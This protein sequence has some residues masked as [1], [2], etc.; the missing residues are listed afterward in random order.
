MRNRT[1]G[2]MLRRSVVVALACVTG[3]A[4]GSCSPFSN[5][6][7]DSWPHFAG[8]EPSDLPPRPGTPGYE[9]FIAHGH[10]VQ[11]TA[12]PATGAQPP[13]ASATAAVPNTAAIAKPTPA[14]ANQMPPAFA[15][16]PVTDAKPDE[17]EVAP[18]V[19]QPAD[20]KS[21]VQGG[22]Y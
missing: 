8:G 1:V 22:L 21:V 4:L 10:P 11:N 12:A 20:D 13:A 18:G 17:E 7:S 2:V 16:P 14:A 9:Q 3:L 15:E 6:V 19:E 5:S